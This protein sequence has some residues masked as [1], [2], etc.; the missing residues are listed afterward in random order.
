MTTL[1]MLLCAITTIATE[2]LPQLETGKVDLPKEVAAP[3]A[4]SL[5]PASY[6]I[7]EDS[8]DVLRFWIRKE[9]PSAA[10]PGALVGYDSLEDGTFLGIMLVIDDT[11]SDFRG[12]SIPVGIYTLRVATHPQDGNHMGIAPSPTFALLCPAADDQNLDTIP[13]DKLM[14][15]SKK[16]AKTGHPCALFLEPF[17]EAPTDPLPRI[18]KNDLEHVVLDVARKAKLESQDADFPIAIV[19]IGKTEAE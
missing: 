8:K 13:R 17:F 18:R 14:E 1:S 19:F 4:E 7:K 10:T 16:A 6:T 3:L 2:D 11:F 12:Q 5:D 15:L 9:V